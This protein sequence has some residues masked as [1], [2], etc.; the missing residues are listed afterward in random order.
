MVESVVRQFSPCSLVP[1]FL[2][3]ASGCSN[4]PLE[5]A[6]PAMDFPVWP[7]GPPSSNGLMGP[8]RREGCIENISE[9]RFSVR[10]PES[11]ESPGRRGWPAVVVCPGGGYRAVCI[12]R[13]GWETAEWLVQRGIAAIVLQY[14]LP[15]GHHSVPGDDLRRTLESVR[16][17]SREWGID[18]ARVGVWGFSAGGHLAASVATGATEDDDS[19]SDR[20]DLLILGYPVITMEAGVTHAGSRRELLGAEPKAELVERF[21][22]EGAV[23]R[24]TPP[25]FLFHAADDL[26]VPVANSRRLHEGLLRVEIESQL[27]IYPSGGH[28]PNVQD[29]NPGWSE[30][31]EAWLKQHGWL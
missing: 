12:N 17:R 21:S 20:P 27:V 25:T 14:R 30:S 2:V 24:Q 6:E 26:A 28:G 29:T 3:L 10:L 15:N 8:P 23:D 18:A 31:L 5:S 1:W 11:P 16:E 13:E 4:P 9:A 7:D 22:L 19:P